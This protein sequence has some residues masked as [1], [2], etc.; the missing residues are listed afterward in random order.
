M[1]A[2]LLILGFGAAVAGL[3]QGISGFAFA[4]VAMA[5]WVWG[6]DPQLE[7]PGDGGGLG[8]WIRTIG[9]GCRVRVGGRRLALTAA[10]TG[11][12]ATAARLSLVSVALAV[13]FLLAAELFGRR[14]QIR[15]GR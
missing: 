8:G 3:V 1:S 10:A 14:L 11:G 15:L 12:E 4:M 2:D 5:I 13:V 6:V 9:V 7:G